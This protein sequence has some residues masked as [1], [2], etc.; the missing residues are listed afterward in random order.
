[1]SS[2]KEMIAERNRR[3]LYWLV[4]HGLYSDAEVWTP[5]QAKRL[6]RIESRMKRDKEALAADREH[7]ET[8]QRKKGQRV[9]TCGSPAADPEDDTG[10]I[11]PDPSDRTAGDCDDQ[12]K[13]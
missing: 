10:T 6:R 1:M 8:C 13:P 4:Q 9:C 5:Y 3:D 11:G 7:G 12:D 2:A